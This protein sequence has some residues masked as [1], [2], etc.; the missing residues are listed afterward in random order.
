MSEEPVSR[1]DTVE[2]YRT[3]AAAKIVL[4]RPDRM[5]AWSTGMA[6]DLLSVL[7][8]LA[9]DDSVRAVMLTGAGRAFCTGADLKDAVTADGATMDTDRILIDWYHPIVT[10]IREMPKPVISAVNGPAAGAGVSLA[11]SA[12]LVVAKESAYF[13]LAFVNIGLLPDAG[14]SLFIP[15]RIGFARFAEM[16]M[17]GERLP[18]PKAADIGLINSSWP[19]DEF[20]KNAEALLTRLSNGPTR[21]YAGTKRELNHWM[22]SGM[23]EQLALEAQ[24]QGEVARS[25]DCAEGIAAFTEK[26]PPRFTGH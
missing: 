12:D 6:A 18:A 15:A 1:L 8:D 26:R 3:G 5:N 24:L 17:L 21:S 20:E 19:D 16:A 22:Y 13:L 10:A 23:A 11:L 2:L 7:G 14:S 9:S 4:N 25:Q